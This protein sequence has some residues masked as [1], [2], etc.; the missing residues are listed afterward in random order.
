[1]NLIFG[2]SGFHRAFNFNLLNLADVPSHEP[3]RETLTNI[4]IWLLEKRDEPYG[5]GLTY[6]EECI[7][8][9]IPEGTTEEQKLVYY[10]I[11]Y[12]SAIGNFPCGFWQYGNEKLFADYKKF[13]ELTNDDDTAVDSS[14]NSQSKKAYFMNQLKN[15]SSASADVGVSYLFQSLVELGN[16]RMD[17][18][19][20]RTAVAQAQANGSNA[21]IVTTQEME[22]GIYLM[23]FSPAEQLLFNN[24][25]NAVHDNLINW[26][27]TTDEQVIMIYGNS[28]PWYAVRIPDM[29]RDNVHIFVHPYNNHY[30]AIENFPETQK[31]EIESLLRQYLY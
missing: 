26:I 9:Q 11:P 29:E 4:Q 28:D 15:S 27:K 25:N 13:Y 31:N 30:S 24:Y 8:L 7:G 23:S 2:L 12:E 18:S 16:Y 14:G 17:F 20:L 5:N 3:Y 10:D 21:K 1:M 6:K 19:Y 22:T